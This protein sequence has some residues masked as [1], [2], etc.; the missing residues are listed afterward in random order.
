[1]PSLIRF[2]VVLGILAGLAYGAMAAL[3]YL[4]EP[5]TR[6]MSVTVPA[7]RLNPQRIVIPDPDPEPADA[8]NLSDGDRGA[9][10]DP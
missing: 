3:V 8:L 10:T 1:M 5:A 2:V 7:D 6:P 9:T 4:V